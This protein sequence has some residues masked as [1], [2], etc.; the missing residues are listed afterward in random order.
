MPD[1]I[2]HVT[3]ILNI[4]SI[5]LKGLRPEMS[6][7]RANVVWMCQYKALTWAIA[8]VALRRKCKPS[9]LMVCSCIMYEE[10]MIRTRWSGIW[11]TRS[12]V[13][14]VAYQS[15]ETWMARIERAGW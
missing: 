11:Q 1:Y 9:D 14:P 13:V 4:D 12:I 6:Q 8:H 3:P 7:G 2:Y 10:E 15:V 5:E